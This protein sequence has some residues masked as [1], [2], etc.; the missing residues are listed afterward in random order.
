MDEQH[1]RLA[2]FRRALLLS[3]ASLIA[4]FAI[5]L[6]GATAA[7]AAEDDAEGGG[8]LGAVTTVTDAVSSAVGDL[9]T[10]A[11]DVVEKAAETAAPVTEVVQ[12]VV[13][14]PVVA[15]VP[16]VVEGTSEVAQTTVD[17]VEATT[18]AAVDAGHQIVE[19]DPVSSVTDAVVS[20]V[21]EIPAVGA[22]VDAVVPPSINDAVASVSTSLDATLQAVIGDSSGSPLTLPEVPTGVLDS[23]VQI[24][25]P[26][27]DEARPMPDIRP[28]PDGDT[29]AVSAASVAPASTSLKQASDGHHGTRGVS[30]T[31]PPVLNTASGI[32]VGD[33]PRAGAPPGGPLAPP[34]SCSLG[35]G[36]AGT[37]PG[38]LHAALPGDAA[39]TLHAGTTVSASSDA[40]PAPPTYPTDV[41]PD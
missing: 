25:V 14:A 21:S 37:G 16:S 22:V 12:A 7:S 17:H 41:S 38:A 30:L 1:H 20:G 4:G 40:V 15:P 18:D 28:D 5:S 9:D 34:G 27:A 8:L 33:S 10:A 23:V 26:A 13:P 24:I 6:A 3:G 31:S 11:S 19:A 36:S 2:G 35:N 39:L 32:D 29:D